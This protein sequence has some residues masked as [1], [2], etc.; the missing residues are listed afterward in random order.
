MTIPADYSKTLQLHLV[1]NKSGHNVCQTEYQTGNIV[2]LNL[3]FSIDDTHYHLS[4]ET[5]D[6]AKKMIVFLE[7][8]IVQDS[9]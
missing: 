6:D 4:P 8:W 2:Q 1:S 7:N 3:L 9:K 5:I